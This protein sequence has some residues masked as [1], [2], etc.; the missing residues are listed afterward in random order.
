MTTT[1]RP[2]RASVMAVAAPAGPP[3]TTTTSHSGDGGRFERAFIFDV[4]H[5]A[6]DHLGHDKSELRPLVDHVETVPPHWRPRGIA[7]L[8][9]PHLVWAL[10][11]PPVR[12]F[13]KRSILEV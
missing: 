12:A 4:L 11:R 5:L 7:S 3:P 13:L 9:A 2:P 6:R 1:E 10:A 8:A